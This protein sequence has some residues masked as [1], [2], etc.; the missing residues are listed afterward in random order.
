M[1]KRI[2]RRSNSY[3]SALEKLQE[4][5]SLLSNSIRKD[6]QVRVCDHLA[7]PFSQAVLSNIQEMSAALRDMQ[8]RALR[9][10]DRAT[11]RFKQ[12]GYGL[13][14]DCGTNIGLKR[15]EALPETELCVVCREAAEATERMVPR[16]DVYCSLPIDHSIFGQN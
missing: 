13:C 16:Y 11:E 1:N 2:K 14:S 15:L 6:A 5:K 9:N 10:V 8:H 12:G 4:K 7:D 3:S